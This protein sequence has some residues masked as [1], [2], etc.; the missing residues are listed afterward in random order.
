MGSVALKLMRNLIGKQIFYF[1]RT[2]LAASLK[3]SILDLIAVGVNQSK[4]LK[5]EMIRIPI[6]FPCPFSQLYWEKYQISNSSSFAT[7]LLWPVGR[8]CVRGSSKNYTFS[9]YVISNVFPEILLAWVPSSQTT[10][11]KKYELEIVFDED[12]KSIQ[13]QSNCVCPPISNDCFIHL[14][15][16]L[17]SK[18]KFQFNL[19]HF[20]Y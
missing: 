8:Q 5:W 11:K 4:A 12:W 2:S 19:M 1:L 17:C 16:T 7:W 20:K 15:R 9:T 10:L 3:I 6:I 14:C 13:A 18:Y